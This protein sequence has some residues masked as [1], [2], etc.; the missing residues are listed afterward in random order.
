[1]RVSEEIRPR[2]ADE[3]VTAEARWCQLASRGR[4]CADWRR[5]PSV[6]DTAGQHRPSELRW[7]GCSALPHKDYRQL[8]LATSELSCQDW[9]IGNRA[10]QE[11]L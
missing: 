6:S 7:N 1:M 2:T 4:V 10:F 8:G 3:G 11:M 5:G 9:C